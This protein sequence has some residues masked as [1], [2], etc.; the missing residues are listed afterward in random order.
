LGFFIFYFYFLFFAFYGLSDIA[1]ND[2]LISGKPN[3]LSGI[4]QKNSTVVP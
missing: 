1:E 4:Y 3:F 2:F